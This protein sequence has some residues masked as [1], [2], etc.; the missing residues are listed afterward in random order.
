MIGY[1]CSRGFV[2]FFRE[3]DSHIGFL[4]SNFT[5]GQALSVPLLML[6]VYLISS[7]KKLEDSS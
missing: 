7:S 2:E 6:G 5:M 3:P 4:Y 1:A